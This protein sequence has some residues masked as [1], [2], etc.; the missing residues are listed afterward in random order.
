MREY[1]QDR[2]FME[3]KVGDIYIRH[4]DGRSY[5]V[6][7]IDHKMVVLESVDEVRLSLTDIFALQKAYSRIEPSPTQ[8]ST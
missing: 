1:L 6:K 2:W 3:I 4:S 5:K 8:G 7:R